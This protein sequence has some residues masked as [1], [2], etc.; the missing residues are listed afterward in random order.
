[1]DGPLFRVPRRREAGHLRAGVGVS[2]GLA[3]A[4]PEWEEINSLSEIPGM[5]QSQ[6]FGAGGGADAVTKTFSDDGK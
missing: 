4:Y 3:G 5:S 6:G 1:M 2:V